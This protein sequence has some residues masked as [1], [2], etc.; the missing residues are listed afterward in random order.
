MKTVLITGA[1][2]FIGGH[3]ARRFLTDNYKVVALIRK[4]SLNKVEKLAEFENFTLLNGN[5]YEQQTLDQITD[6]IDVI[7]H[8][9]SIRGEGGGDKK[10]Y[11]Q[12]NIDGTRVLLEFAKKNKIPGFIYCSSVGVLGTIPKN[13]P[14]D[15]QQLVNPDNLYHTSKWQSE[16]IVNEYHNASL[17]TCVLR[18][19]ITYGPGDDGFIPKLVE[20]VKSGKFPLSSKDVFIHLLDVNAFANFV[21]NLVDLSKINGKTYIIADRMPVLLKDLVNLIAKS[22]QKG[23]GF[24]KIPAIVFRL[25]ESALRLLNQKKLLTSIQLISRSWTY[26]IDETVRDLDYRAKDTLEVIR[27]YIK[28]SHI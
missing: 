15:V 16:V 17:S 3:M 2:G 9:A 20:L 12:I 22:F 18:P 28:E 25:G 24:L 14:A 1:S 13:Q 11:R 27:A 23:S 7:L 4:E 19:T 8:F 21:Y 5:F 6:K 26:K 10:T